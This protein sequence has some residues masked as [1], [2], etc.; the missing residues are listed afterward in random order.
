MNSNLNKFIDI[1]KEM[2]SLKTTKQR[3]K[4]KLNTKQ[5]KIKFKDAEKKNYQHMTKN[6]E[7]EHRK[8]KKRLEIVCAPDYT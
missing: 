1:L 8:L 3:F 6:M 5:D 2:K 7:K 4:S